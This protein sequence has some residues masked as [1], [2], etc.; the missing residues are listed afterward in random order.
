MLKYTFSKLRCNSYTVT[1]VWIQQFK[2]ADPDPQPFIS[3]IFR[4]FLADFSFVSNSARQQLI[5]TAGLYFQQC[6]VPGWQLTALMCVYAV[7][8]T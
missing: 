4:L 5:M 8:L 2:Y 1:R 6:L 7:S 3:T